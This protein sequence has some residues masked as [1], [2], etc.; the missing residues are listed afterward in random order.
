MLS[1]NYC[2]TTKAF[3]FE[4][5]KPRSTSMSYDPKARSNTSQEACSPPHL[6]HRAISSARGPHG[7][8]Y[9][10]AGYMRLADPRA[11]SDVILEKL[12]RI[13][14]TSEQSD[15]HCRRQRSYWSIAHP[16]TAALRCIEPCSVKLTRSPTTHRSRPIL[17]VVRETHRSLAQDVGID[18]L[19]ITYEDL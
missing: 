14:C 3:A 19:E 15:G 10:G 2:T 4:A 9:V 1:T 18:L 7:P 8:G 17:R 5:K 13:T 12:P 11:S 6:L 16:S